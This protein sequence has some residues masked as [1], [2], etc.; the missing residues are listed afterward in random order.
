MS[1]V[2]D[3][4]NK[5]NYY[6]FRGYHAA[7]ERTR[8]SA[9]NV[10][11]KVIAAQKEYFRSTSGILITDEQLKII[12]ILEESMHKLY[13][14]SLAVEQLH[15]VTNYLKFTDRS[16]PDLYD[17]LLTSSQDEI[18]FLL[19]SLFD[20]TLYT[21][22][23]FLDF[24]LKYLLFYCT[25]DYILTMSIKEFKKKM[26]MWINTHEADKSNVVYD[27]LRNNV[28]CREFG[29]GEVGW[30]DY[31]RE[32]RDKTTHQKLIMP[33]IRQ[34]QNKAGYIISW[35]TIN[36]QNYSELA[37]LNF[38]NMAFKMIMDLFPI[39]YNIKWVN[40]PYKPD[41]HHSI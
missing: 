36:G 15:G 6:I 13:S 5:G 27:Y 33:T 12:E 19:S 21:W 31:L 9:R 41:N 32:L 28:L 35:P 16:L 3:E 40:R 20:Q 1:E 26:R 25:G 23:S 4:F 24:Y 10:Y 22:R 7:I 18:V 14:A 39:L 8:S 17:A 37:Q 34:N 2:L 38:E 29:G 30:G 11:Y